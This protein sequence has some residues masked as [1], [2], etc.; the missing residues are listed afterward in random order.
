M[1]VLEISASAR[2]QDSVSRLLSG[3]IVAAL[4]SGNDVTLR[5]RDL[6]EGL[7]FVDAGWI[8]ANFTAEDQRSAA[9]H[10]ALALSNR[11]VAELRDADVLVIGTP[12]YNFGIPASLKA[13][14]DMIARARLTFRYT[15]DGP[16]GLLAGRKAYVAVASGGVAIGGPADFV[17][18]YLKHV[19]RFIGITD[20]EIIAAEGLNQA[21]SNG[22]EAAREQIAE[23]IHT[24]RADKDLAA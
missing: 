22:V 4:R 12:V 24:G 23:L 13:W 10:D 9:Q 19:L 14:I 15:A 17:T 3:E 11:L 6:A 20:V 5:R 8:D 16:E 1:K 21:G 18:P 7:P 2:Q